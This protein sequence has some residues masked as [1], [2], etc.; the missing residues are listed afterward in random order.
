[1]A[2][3]DTQN[4]KPKKRV[5]LNASLEELEK[6][7]QANSA[8]GMTEEEIKTPEE[9]KPVVS[10]KKDISIKPK[11]SIFEPDPKPFKLASGDRFVKVPKNEIQ[12]RRMGAAEESLFYKLISNN[13]L[14]A[15]NNTM[16]MVIDACVKTDIDIYDLSLIDKL[17]I[18]LFIQHLTYGPLQ[19]NPICPDCGSEWPFTLDLLSLKVNYLPQK[20]EYP[21]K[22]KMT[23]F[24]GANIYWYITY[25]TIKQSSEYFEQDMLSGLK[26]LTLKFEGTIKDPATG[27]TREISEAD[28]ES[29]IENL[30]DDDMQAFRDFQND[31]GS[32]TTEMTF[33]VPKFCQNKICPQF[34][35]DQTFDV[36]TNM[37]FDRIIKLQ[38]K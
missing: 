27:E 34:G 5:I 7:K 20:F 28:Y 17:P 12:V 15:I 36:P 21:F 6:L 11:K 37:L 29:I 3:Q 18:F 14:T 38:S 25:P 22:Y 35:K 4:G 19:M 32:Y 16:D 13:N 30:N 2:D 33:T 10:E 24:K 8:E 31:F 9:P 26:L 1:M 23:S